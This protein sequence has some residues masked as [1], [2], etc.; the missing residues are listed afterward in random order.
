MK[1]IKIMLLSLLLLAVVGGVLAFKA[2]FVR[3]YCTTLPIAN[4]SG[5]LVCPT[6][7]ICPE[8]LNSTS[9]GGFGTAVTLCVTQKPFGVN[10]NQISA[11]TTLVSLKRN[12]P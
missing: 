1:K 6:T 2:K 11:C 4:G 3:T 8:M 9:I 10:C 5:Q 12:I 7:T